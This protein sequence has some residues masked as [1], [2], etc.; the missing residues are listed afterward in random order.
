MKRPV[1]AIILIILTLAVIPLASSAISSAD[2]DNPPLRAGDYYTNGIMIIIT[3][4][5]TAGVVSIITYIGMN[6]ISRSIRKR[7]LEKK[8]KTRTE[9]YNSQENILHRKH[10]R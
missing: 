7:K 2:T 8:R 9:L 3:C 4:T 10:L 5:I 6:R 1:V